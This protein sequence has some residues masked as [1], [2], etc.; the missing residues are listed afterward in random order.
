MRRPCGP[1][2]V[3]VTVLGCVG[4]GYWVV[5]SSTQVVNR[6]D[7]FLSGIQ[8]NKN[9]V[10]PSSLYGLVPSPLGERVG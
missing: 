6:C 4:G 10:I 9:Y 1:D 3:S 5:V 2:P 8:N 7:Y